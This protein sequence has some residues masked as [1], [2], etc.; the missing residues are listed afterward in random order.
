MKVAFLTLTYLT[1]T[2]ATAAQQQ[3]KSDIEAMRMLAA[4]SVLHVETSLK[5][6]NAAGLSDGKNKIQREVISPAN[7]LLKAWKDYKLTD[8]QRMPYM[9]CQS[10]LGD[11]QVYS[12][13]ALQPP[14][15]HLSPVALQKLKFINEDLIECRKVA[16]SKKNSG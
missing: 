13:D 4:Q 14:K 11:V 9:A 3:Q 12:A 2:I 1:M 7:V 16:A 5:K 6:I 8:L 10:I 15:Y